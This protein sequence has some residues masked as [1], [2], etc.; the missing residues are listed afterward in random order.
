[1]KKLFTII[2]SL[3]CCINW[4]YAFEV[5]GLEYAV[6]DGEATVKSAENAQREMVVVPASVTYEGETYK[7]TSISLGAFSGPKCHKISSVI[8]SE[9][10]KYIGEEVF[11]SN[12]EIKEIIFSNS[13]EKIGKNACRN[14]LGLEKVVFPERLDTIPDGL[15]YANMV[16]SK[17]KEVVM[18]KSC[19]VIGKDAFMFNNQLEFLVLPDDLQEIQSGA[20]FEC[21]KLQTKIPSTVKHIGGSA[22][23]NTLSPVNPVNFE[24][25]ILE[26]GAF[27]RAKGLTH[28]SIPEQITNIPANCFNCCSNIETIEFTNHLDT[29]GQRAFNNLGKLK[30]IILPSSV[31]YIG[32][33][34]FA[35]CHILRTVYARMEYPPYLVA[36]EFG[37][38]GFSSDNP[39]DAVVYVPV[40][41]KGNYE[42]AGW[43]K[44]FAQIVEM[45]ET[46]Q[47]QEF[48]AIAT[49][50][51]TVKADDGVKPSGWYDLQG[52]RLTEPRKGVNIIRYNDGTARKVLK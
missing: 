9:G 12:H 35:K 29:I 10:I 21:L 1:M 48:D 46:E 33:G 27:Q 11:T 32:Y 37:G 38:E 23:E 22:F 26:P 24:N 28:L 8:I 30:A 14:M 49:G 50:I 42:R 39:S 2:I 52:R 7:V 41:C 40:G 18:P 25:I 34:A 16:S 15:C 20:F 31:E 17:L 3:I 19:K 45:E 36:Y 51:S 6:I 47:K 44:Y 13:V 4:A 43:G 5:D